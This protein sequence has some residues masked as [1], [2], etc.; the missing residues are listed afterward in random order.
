MDVK[1]MYSNAFAPSGRTSSLHHTQG[2]ALGYVLVA[3]SGRALNACICALIELAKHEKLTVYSLKFR[4]DSLEP[5][6]SGREPT[7][8]TVTL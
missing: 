4:D 3:P 2:N 5:I 1:P 6:E 8:P 7:V